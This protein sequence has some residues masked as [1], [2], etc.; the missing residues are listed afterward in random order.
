MPRTGPLEETDW[1]T[2]RSD[3]P[4]RS[5]RGTPV[6][7]RGGQQNRRSQL[8]RVARCCSLELADGRT[9]VGYLWTRTRVTE[10]DDSGSMVT[11]Q[12]GFSRFLS[13][14]MAV[15]TCGFT[16]QEH[17][18]MRTDSMT[19]AGCS[20]RDRPAG[21]NRRRSRNADRPGPRVS[22]SGAIGRSGLR[23][24]GEHRSTTLVEAACALAD[25]F[26]VIRS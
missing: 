7:A 25:W 12:W 5:K 11:M 23:P 18:P 24:G 17:L 3:S 21:V 1:A 13:V 16:N 8:I 6:R 26:Q 19:P 2:S 14:M 10:V 4:I 20:V 22:Y 9:S 15:G